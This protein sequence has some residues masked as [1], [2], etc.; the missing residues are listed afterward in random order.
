MWAWTTWIL[1]LVGFVSETISL[2]LPREDTSIMNHDSRSF[3]NVFLPPAYFTAR[4]ITQYMR[5]MQTEA[6]TQR[7]VIIVKCLASPLLFEGQPYMKLILSPCFFHHFRSTCVSRKLIL[8][9]RY[10][11]KSN[12]LQILNKIR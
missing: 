7:W 12:K 2:K 4:I 9:N 8:L 3:F 11:F 1:L 10:L 6:S 5:S